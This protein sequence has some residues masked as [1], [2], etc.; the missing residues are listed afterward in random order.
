MPVNKT[1]LTQK[2]SQLEE[3][4]R[5]IERMEFTL[6]E[7][8]STPDIQDLLTFRLIQGVEIAIDIATHLIAALGL[9]VPENAAS[10]FE[11]LAQ[12]KI[13]VRSL[14]KSLQQAVGFRNLAVHRYTDLDFRRLYHDYR[15]DLND[16]REFVRQISRYLQ[17]FSLNRQGWIYT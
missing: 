5:R 11:V 17:D 16:L 9:K 14:A 8:E 3:I 13:I 15:Q 2:L 10:S 1:L 12:K 4:I 7:L 6:A